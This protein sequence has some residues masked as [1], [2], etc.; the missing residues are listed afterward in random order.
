MST[1]LSSPK[2]L[3]FMATEQSLVC[4]ILLC[5]HDALESPNRASYPQLA[6]HGWLDKIEVTTGRPRRCV[7]I[8]GL[9]A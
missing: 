6:K 1:S 5:H 3:Y 8:N 2:R 7:C 4:T 9:E